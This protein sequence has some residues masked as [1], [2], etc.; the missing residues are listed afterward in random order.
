MEQT[1]LEPHRDF[2]LKHEEISGMSEA[3]FGNGKDGILTRLGRMEEKQDSLAKNQVELMLWIRGVGVAVIG[4]I[5]LA[6]VKFV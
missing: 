1:T 3:I 6:L 4:G 5:I 2:C